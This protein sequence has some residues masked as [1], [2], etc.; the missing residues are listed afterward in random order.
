[1]QEGVGMEDRRFDLFVDILKIMDIESLKQAQ[2]QDGVKHILNNFDGVLTDTQK[3]KLMM[4]LR[5]IAFKKQED[6]EMK[7]IRHRLDEE[8]Y[9]DMIQSFYR[10]SDVW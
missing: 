2:L 4:E 6:E 8:I 3:N 10:T 9:R 5:N 7:R 1:M